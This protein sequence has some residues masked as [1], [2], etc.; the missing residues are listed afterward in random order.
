MK[1]S[2][3]FMAAVATAAALCVCWA[4]LP[5]I[6]APP[7]AA[8]ASPGW[9]AS[10]SAPGVSALPANGA[11]PVAQP[12]KA[13]P[14]THAGMKRLARN[15][16]PQKP[17]TFGPQKPVPTQSAP[18]QHGTATPLPPGTQLLP[19]GEPSG[20]PRAGVPIYRDMGNTATYWASGTD[21]AFADDFITAPNQGL[22][23]SDLQVGVYAPAGGAA[24]DVT[25]EI[26]QTG[27]MG[28]LVTGATYT[29]TA[30]PA[31]GNAYILSGSFDPL[32]TLPANDQF[33]PLW[34]VYTITGNAD[35]GA[36]IG[37][38]ADIGYTADIFAINDPTNGWGCTWYLGG[39]P[40][41]GFV[42]QINAFGGSWACCNGTS[43]V[44]STDQAACL[45]GGG[46]YFPGYTCADAPCFV[47]SGTPTE[48]EACGSDT[49]GGCNMT[50]PAFAPITCGT[51]VIGT[52]WAD[53]S[54]RDTDWY[55]ITITQNTM[56]LFDAVGELPT[57]IGLAATDPVGS[58]DCATFT[59]LAPYAAADPG[60]TA[61]IRT[62]CLPAGTYW[63]VVMPAD[64]QQWPC[65]RKY[66]ATLTCI[67]PCPVE[68]RFTS[69][70]DMTV[71]LT[72]PSGT[73]QLHFESVCLDDLGVI[74]RDPPPYATGTNIGLDMDFFAV[75]GADADLGDLV[76]LE[77]RERKSLGSVTG[78]VASGG[79]FV[80]G[81]G[82][83]FDDY[84]DLGMFGATSTSA[85][86]NVGPFHLTLVNPPL[87]QLPPYTRSY[88][89]AGGGAGTTGDASGNG[90]TNGQD[91]QCFVNCL[92]SSG[93]SC[94]CDCADMD[95]N[96]QVNLADIPL[97]VNVLLGVT[98][99]QPCGAGAG[100]PLIPAGQTEPIGQVIALTHTINRE[101]CD[102][103]VYSNGRASD[104]NALSA[105]RRTDG[106]MDRWIADDVVLSNAPGTTITAIEW[107]TLESADFDP[108]V[109][110]TVDVGIW[111]QASLGGPPQDQPMILRE[112]VPV[113][114]QGVGYPTVN[115]NVCYTVTL[116]PP[117][118]LPPNP[119]D[120]TYFFGVRPV[121]T[122]DA[123]I[124]Q[125]FWWVTGTLTGQGVYAK[126]TDY[127]DG[128]AWQ[129]SA[130]IFG[131][132]YDAAFC[133]IGS[134]GGTSPTGAC[135]WLNGTTPM[136]DTTGNVV[137]CAIKNGTFMGAGTTCGTN[138]CKG[139][140]CYEGTT[141]H[142]NTYV[143]CLGAQTYSQ[144]I[145]RPNGVFQGP[146]TTCTSAPCP[147]ILGACCYTLAGETCSTCEQ[148]SATDCEAKP[149]YV[150]W[151]LGV[152]CDPLACMG[153]CGACCVGTTC[154][155]RDP[156]TCYGMGGVWYYN[157]PC[158]PLPCG[159]SYGTDACTSTS[160][161]PLT[162]GS[163]INLIGDT[164][165][166]TNDCATLVDPDVWHAFSLTECM[167]V[168]IQFCDT[169]NQFPTIWIV[170]A[171][172]CPCGALTYGSADF[173]TCASG[174]P[175]VRFPLLQPGVYYYP[176]WAGA[177]SPGPYVGTIT[178]VACPPLCL[179]QITKQ[180]GDLDEDTFEPCGSSTDGGCNSTPNAFFTPNLAN[181]NTVF[182]SL[183]ATGG[184]RD[185]DW[186]KFST[187]AT[188]Q[189]VVW[190]A[191]SELPVALYILSTT[192]GTPP[193]CANASVYALGFASCNSPGAA[194]AIL[195]SNGIYYLFIGPGN[196]LG[197]I[198]DGYPCGTTNGGNEY[199]ATLTISAAPAAPANDNCTGAINIT[200]N[201]N[202]T[203]VTGDTLA[204]NTDSTG[205]FDTCYSPSSRVPKSVWYK[206]TAPANGSVTIGLCPSNPNY[207]L[208]DGVMALYSGTS[209]TTLTQLICNDD[210]C[211]VSA[212]PPYYPKIVRTGL[213][214][215]TMYYFQFGTWPK[216]A[217][218]S[219]GNPGPY[220]VHI[221]SP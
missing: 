68:D 16:S 70:L 80:S 178:G 3:T 114:R 217:G 62:A 64:W 157:M 45:A 4:L 154:T 161:V 10:P 98:Q 191:V 105:E 73:K 8:P 29:W 189:K 187:G 99:P 57:L 25:V 165:G 52:Y 168:T 35:A 88:S 121:Q 12:N 219:F 109:P 77:S 118:I 46:V 102:L 215:G 125:S 65:T 43:C 133:L 54:N 195:P 91:V 193:T 38:P 5:A 82:S 163:T 61:E 206:F 26:H 44:D 41:V 213:T 144:C 116:T 24:Y 39:N 87:T 100:V 174:Q 159:N 55:Q 128:I 76:L 94:T 194:E 186:F 53:N 160:I 97:F 113:T 169:V 117:V 211:D 218:T 185:T 111:L 170:V 22:D 72:N 75:R 14:T 15:P 158:T 153:S 69:T 167:D 101:P 208:Y 210:S 93:G 104:V 141:S 81:T 20:S 9:E 110:P 140:C 56:F 139:A 184:T 190:S 60:H 95:R 106:T 180:T 92:L 83:F 196:L 74:Y 34:L 40:Y 201:I 50:T 19:F 127:G 84:I 18:V 177:G 119:A 27:C 134:Q 175:T 200:A 30:V 36:L 203:D 13:G 209:C 120:R 172:S 156:D 59:G 79:N 197:A 147:P 173:T 212:A 71:Q 17:M 207:G 67:S 112:N 49:N 171:N 148:L 182:G 188:N 2:G 143:I 78:V 85:F 181:G 164:T 7:S 42:A 202:G 146:G 131:A 221:T 6:A 124:G 89:W 58:S 28:D 138:T 51:P 214:P 31:D 86:Y 152:V 103:A 149:G 135:C 192:T 155:R 145:A 37:G 90:I 150:S 107:C 48:T 199:R 130:T 33:T 176:V 21:L 96:G 11:V 198:Y 220:A 216:V 108:T 122:P 162:I 137:D 142:G 183:W 115:G 129:P 136:C 32:V 47:V 126:G 166:A 151:G 63:F 66:T 123:T 179:P 1:S 132:D 205:P 23:M 204:A